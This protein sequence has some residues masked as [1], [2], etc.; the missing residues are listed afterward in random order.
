ME[1]VELGLRVCREARLVLMLVSGVGGEVEV[2]VDV[3]LDLDWVAR[4]C[5][6]KA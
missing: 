6:C 2:E 1:W 3:E 4:C 5:M